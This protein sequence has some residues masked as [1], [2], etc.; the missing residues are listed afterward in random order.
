MLHLVV[1]SPIR[2]EK[3]RKR[4]IDNDLAILLSYDITPLLSFLVPR[5]FSTARSIGLPYCPFFLHLPLPI[6]ELPIFLPT[7]IAL[8][9]WPFPHTSFQTLLPTLLL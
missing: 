5:N 4:N 7:P 8:V 9:L 2:K 3:K 1:V 6:L